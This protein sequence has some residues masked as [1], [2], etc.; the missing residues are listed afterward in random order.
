MSYRSVKERDAGQV[1]RLPP[2]SVMACRV[3]D[4][5]IGD[6]VVHEERLLGTMPLL[7]AHRTN[8]Y[9]ANML[10]MATWIAPATRETRR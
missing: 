6:R 2:T 7:R 8:P 1:S 5:S 3:I 4:S 9:V 10:T